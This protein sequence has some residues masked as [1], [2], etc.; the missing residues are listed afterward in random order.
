[1]PKPHIMDG[2]TGLGPVQGGVIVAGDPPMRHF[3]QIMAG[4]VEPV[5]LKF[6]SRRGGQDFEI[7]VRNLTPVEIIMI[8]NR[9][10]AEGQIEFG[11]RPKGGGGPALMPGA[12]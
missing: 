11:F 3:E 4:D 6:R 10:L 5:A 8:V 1:M 12:Q 2:R 7:P 9:A